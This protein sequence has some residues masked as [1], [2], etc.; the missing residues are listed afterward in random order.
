MSPPSRG[1]RPLNLAWSMFDRIVDDETQRVRAQCKACG[2]Q[3]VPQVKRM[4]AHVQWCSKLPGTPA[5]EEYQRHLSE[6]EAMHASL[7]E[8]EIAADAGSSCGSVRSLS[9]PENPPAKRG[10]QT[11]LTVVRT[12]GSTQ[13]HIWSDLQIF[14]CVKFGILRCRVQSLAGVA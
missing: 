7:Q 1:G 12:D 8:P 3:L 5:M 11:Q 9:S 14:G 13:R 10:A 6:L 4:S 2:R